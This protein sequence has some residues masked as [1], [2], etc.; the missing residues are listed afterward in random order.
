[1]T[2]LKNILYFISIALW[3]SN[4][5][6]A[7]SITT[8][9]SILDNI[10]VINTD[11]IKDII[12]QSLSKKTKADKL[13]IDIKGYENGIKLNSKHDSYDVNIAESSVNTNSRRFKYSLTFTSGSDTQKFDITGRYDEIVKVPVLISEIEHS[14]AITADNIEY[15]EM[16]KSKLQ[17]NTITDEDALLGKILKH[18]IPSG[19]PI[20]TSDIEKQIIVSRGK[21]VNILFKTPSMTLQTSGVAMDSGG[22]GEV[23]RVRNSSSEKIIQAEIQNEELVSVSS[24]ALTK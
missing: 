22:K 13:T 23:I 19:R 4:S 11:K 2:R 16:P 12:S 5:Y 8:E 20:R 3:V 18:S 7:V 15:A 14:T 10:S 24:Q 21:A 17:N 1:M 6:A 9:P